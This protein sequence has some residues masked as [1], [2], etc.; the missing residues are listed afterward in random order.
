MENDY[1]TSLSEDEVSSKELD[2]FNP[3]SEAYYDVKEKP[4]RTEFYRQPEQRVLKRGMLIYSVIILIMS[5]IDYFL[6]WKSY[7]GFDDVPDRVF[8]TIQT[9]IFAVALVQVPILI[10][11][12]ELTTIIGIILTISTLYISLTNLSFTSIGL[13]SMV[14][15]AFQFNKAQAIT[16]KYKRKYSDV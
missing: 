4:T 9:L 14:I 12:N 8:Y 1:Y 6:L 7:D 11:A 13:V 3:E 2:S 10:W 15:A 16:G 5:V